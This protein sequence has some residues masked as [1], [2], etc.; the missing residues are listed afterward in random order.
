MA[1]L[2]LNKIKLNMMLDFTKEEALSN[3]GYNTWEN[4]NA[5]TKNKKNVASTEGQ[6]NS[7]LA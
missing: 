7:T 6:S 5:S 4:I 2:I 3:D 1:S